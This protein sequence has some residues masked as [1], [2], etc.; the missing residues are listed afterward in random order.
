MLGRFTPEQWEYR[1]AVCEEGGFGPAPLLAGRGWVQDHLLVFD[2][3]TGEGA[4]FLPRPDRNP[5]YE[6][7]Q[8][9]Q[10]W[11]CPLFEPF[12]H[13]LYKQDLSDLTALP[14]SVD[15]PDAEFAFSG[16]R[17]KGPA[18]I[19]PSLASALVGVLGLA[20]NHQMW[21]DPLSQTPQMKDFTG[22]T[23]EAIQEVRAFLKE[24][25]IMTIHELT[26][27]LAEVPARG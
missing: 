27:R 20:E 3:Q 1:S 16:H 17:R 22:R 12:L 26:Q 8:K 24:N 19:T 13:W 25:G 9:H 6:L 15:L 10:I 7:N 11:V 14:R 2:L 4:M 5:S 21:T 23:Y 18:Q